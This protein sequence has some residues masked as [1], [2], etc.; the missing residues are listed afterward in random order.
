MRCT[1][2]GFVNPGGAKYCEQCGARLARICARCGQASSSDARF[3]NTCG[4]SFGALQQPIFASPIHYTPPYLAERILA[5]RAA[6][7]DRGPTA[8]E[9]KTI[10][11]LFADMAGSTAMIQDLDPEDA[12]RLINPVITLMMEAVHHYEGYVAKSLG[13]GILALFGAPIAQEDHALRALYAAL[14][15]QEA[16]RWHSERVRLNQGPTLQIRIGVH[17]GEVVVRAIHKDDLHTDYDPVGH[18]I[19]IASRLEGLANISSILV[20]ASTYRLTEGHFSFKA[21]GSIQV[22]GVRDPLP[23]YAVLGLGA[24]RTRLQVAA[25]RGWARFVGRQTELA[26]LQQ[27]LAQAV[28][29]HGQVVALVGDAGVGKSRLLHEFKARSQSRCLALETFSLSHGKAFAYLPLIELLRNY[30]QIAATDDARRCRAKILRKVRRLER[31]LDELLPF[32]F[33]L[34]GVAEAGSSLVDMDAT[35]RRERIFDAILRLL[36][37]ESV[38]QP[39]ELLF[40]DQQWLDSETESFLAFLMDRLASTRILLLV[41]YR[42]E[43]RPPWRA[44][45]NYTEVRLEPLAPADAQA[46]L[47]ALLGED[48]GL[49]LL[50]QR[51]LERTEGN[52]YFIEEVVR[53]LVEEKVLLDGPGHY[54]IEAVPLTLQLPTTVQGVLAARMDRLPNAEKGLLQSL[55]VIG[56]EFPWSLIQRVCGGQG[57]QAADELRLLLSR[58]EAAEFIFERAAFPEVEYAFKHALTREVARN[59]LLTEQRSV[60]HERTAEAIEAL[61]PG[62]LQDYFGELAHHYSASGN[63]SKALEYLHRAGHQALQQS[64]NLEAIRHLNTGLEMLRHLPESTERDHRELTL[65]LLLG[66]ALMAARGYAAVEVEAVYSRALALCEAVGEHTQIFPVQMGLLTYYA[67]RAEY[68]TAR[69]LG[70][71]LLRIAQTAHDPSLLVEAHSAL[72]SILFSQGNFGAARAHHEHLRKIYDPRQHQTHA[73]IYGTAPGIRGL[74]FY[75]WNLWYLGYPDQALKASR[76]ALARAQESAHPLSL[77]FTLASVATLHQLRREPRLSLEYAEAAIAL[78][79]NHGFPFWLAR[80]TVLQGWGLAEHGT[81]E[82]GIARIRQGL[83]AYQ[84][85]GAAVGRTYQLGLLA[86]ALGHAGQAHG[87]LAILTDALAMANK[88]GERYYEAELHRLQGELILSTQASTAQQEAEACFHRAI[89]VARHQAAK[90]IELRATASLARLWQAQGKT[91]AARRTLAQAYAFFTEGFGTADLQQAK[92]LLDDLARG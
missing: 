12:H 36:V 5:E 48:P 63:I 30:F 23:V 21:L 66:P 38:N 20:S 87:G 37:R 85:T 68:P 56:H 74:N 50:K 3:C 90:S 86:A 47:G 44:T 45:D 29:G 32:L 15:M 81:I 61:N 40:E 84:A 10:T 72:E 28:A 75:A 19:H 7:I 73:F 22:K 26:Q 8:G 2:C 25:H 17:S 54:R 27:A 78:S 52:P 42:P 6:L 64:A 88:T 33:H 31:S 62:R 9:R 14:R 16:M 82:L 1:K 51:L 18:T 69:D 35:I 46:L 24:L 53:A 57:A 55:A 34:L 79:R 39:L 60:L 83:E 80:E 67:L 59:S 91:D 65:L 13:D 70:E 77:A 49:A 41:N 4:A 89:A 71:R 58:L 43:Y 11:A 76:E 92:T